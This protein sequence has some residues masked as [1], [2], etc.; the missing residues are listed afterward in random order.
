LNPETH[1]VEGENQFS[2][3]VLQTAHMHHGVYVALPKMISLVK[4]E[5]GKPRSLS[6][7]DEIRKSVDQ[8]PIPQG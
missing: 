8:G 4:N 3:A 7:S 1:I 2:Q 6:A 5:K